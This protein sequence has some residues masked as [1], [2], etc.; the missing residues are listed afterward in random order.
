MSFVAS[1]FSLLIA[2]DFFSQF[3]VVVLVLSGSAVF[4]FSAYALIKLQYKKKEVLEVL[5]IVKNNPLLVKDSN[6][7][8][9]LFFYSMQKECSEELLDQMVTSYLYKEIKIKLF[10]GI[11][12][13]TGPL[14]GL[15]GTIWGV[16][17]VFVVIQGSFD[18]KI[19]APGIA[20]ALITTLAGL[21]VAIPASI[22]Y[23]IVAFQIKSYVN[24]VELC[25]LY[26]KEGQCNAQKK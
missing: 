4:I 14:L 21:F 9:S 24:R 1:L 22:A 23:H 6:N 12:A 25:Y 3:L 8:A 11:M 26:Y 19:I 7:F 20:E 17:H 2:S 15:L 18:I 16:M 10:F 5:E 13:V